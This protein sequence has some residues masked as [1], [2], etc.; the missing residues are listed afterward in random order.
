MTVE[1]LIGLLTAGFVLGLS[2]VSLAKAAKDKP[3]KAPVP[4][5][6]KRP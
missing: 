6:H 2:A 4:V 3:K 1:S 5:R